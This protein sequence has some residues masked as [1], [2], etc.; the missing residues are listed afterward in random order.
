[1]E[2]DGVI[3]V[4]DSIDAPLSYP[5]LVGI[6]SS[7]SGSW[8]K[9]IDGS[10]IQV[11]FATATFEGGLVI[12]GTTITPGQPNYPWLARFEACGTIAPVAFVN[13]IAPNG[14]EAWSL[15]ATDTVKWFG[16]LAH[17]FVRI[18]L[19]RD[20]P[21]AQWEELADSV[22][23]DGIHIV[24][25]QGAV[26]L[27][28]RIRVSTLGDTLSDISNA[29]FSIDAAQGFLTLARTSSPNSPILSWSAV[30]TECPNSASQTF[31]MKNF[32]SEPI[33]VFQPLEP[34]TAE[35]SRTTSCGSF[36]AL[37]PGGI[38]AC[39][40]TVSFAPS[41]DGLIHDTLRIQT[42]AVNGIGGFVSI[43][44]SGSQIRTP[45]S[46]EVVISTVGNNAILRWS[47]IA[48]SVGHCQI[49]PPS[50]LV[51]FS[52]VPDGPFWFHGGT[53]D[54]T[55]TH[56]WAIQHT[57]AMFYHVYAV[58]ADPGLLASL[59]V[60]NPDLRISEADIIQRFILAAER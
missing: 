4:G 36:F 26:S 32:G 35:Y 18:E 21:S 54:T 39:S 17:A 37:A 31:R 33:V 45:E 13:V 57:T 58:Q 49:D 20:F 15:F 59:P 47:P 44:L 55:Y 56:V 22:E 7:G 42:D 51:F 9:V 50:Y 12:A 46:P 43:P 24:Q 48:E 10:P 16:A 38:S 27:N 5:L 11:G 8:T 53:N 2:D 34:V 23:N 52:E 1:M 41:S 30:G 25:V 6:D 14:G 19:N 40:L 28:C 60:W 3:A 29:D